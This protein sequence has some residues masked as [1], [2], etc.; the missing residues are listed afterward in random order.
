MG[1]PTHSLD[2][3]AADLY[4]ASILPPGPSCLDSP[5]PSLDSPGSSPLPEGH[6]MFKQEDG[7]LMRAQVRG[8]L[9]ADV[10]ASERTTQA[11]SVMR[12]SSATT[13]DTHVY[14]IPIN[15]ELTSPPSTFFPPPG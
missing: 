15:T 4:Y 13:L 9:R 10:C 1:G 6:T 3:D 2:F 14:W 5:L 11:D 12:L 8:P 7:P